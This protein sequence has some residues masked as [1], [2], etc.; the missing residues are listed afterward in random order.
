MGLALLAAKDLVGVEI[1]VV[2]QTHD[3]PVLGT[4]VL[5]SIAAVRDLSVSLPFLFLSCFDISLQR[6][7]SLPLSRPTPEDP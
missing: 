2:S 5:H 1:D 4:L 3:C 7:S 6:L